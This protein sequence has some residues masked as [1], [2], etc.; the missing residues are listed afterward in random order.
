MSKKKEQKILKKVK[1]DYNSISDHFDLTRKHPWKEFEAF[2]PYLRDDI[3]IA[4]VGCGNGRF[5]EH[6]KDEGYKADYLG[7]DN[8]EKLLEIAQKKHPEAKF[9]LGELQNIPIED[10]KVDLLVEI[11]SFHHLPNK[12]LRN[13]ALQEAYRVLVKGG[14]FIITT[15]N[16]FQ[17]K[18]KKYIWK[19]RLKSLFSHY[20]PRDTFIPWSDTGIDR[21]YYAF[22]PKELQKLI[23]NNGF[24]ILKSAVGRNIVFICEKK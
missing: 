24:K 23:E 12:E 21:Y 2:K 1:S 14:I 18:Y 3:F 4:D 20:S 13:K 10:H 7:I 17:K 19:A 8:S 5:Y 22:T 16:L 9:I 11:A 6:L 15:W